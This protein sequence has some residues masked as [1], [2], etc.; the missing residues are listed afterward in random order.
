[1]EIEQGDPQHVRDT[2]H[3]RDGNIKEVYLVA[4]S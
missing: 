2:Q 1:M 3:V 4:L